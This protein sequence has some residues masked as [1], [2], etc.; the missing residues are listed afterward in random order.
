MEEP[1][2]CDD[3]ATGPSDVTNPSAPPSVNLRGKLVA[4]G[5]VTAALQEPLHR[6]LNDMVSFR[7]L[8][9]APAPATSQI[10][11]HLI[12][13]VGAD[14]TRV[15]FTIYDLSDDAPIGTTSVTHIDH[16]HRT[17]EL[18]IAIMEIER[19]GKG[20]GTEAVRLVT[21]YAILALEM[22]NVQLRAFACNHAGI[23]AYRKAG[24]R[25]YGRRREA[26][27]HH[28]H[29]CDVVYM[30]VLASEWGGPVAAKLL[31]PDSERL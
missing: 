14:P 15:T 29:R 21:D 20:L 5:P 27:L 26:W 7:T 28:G 18:D 2:R 9:A 25:E 8:G 23:R 22:H 19:R 10:A 3:D 31:A 16:R 1:R 4:L 24:F 30:E 11:Q 12:D 6:W 13:E 17:C